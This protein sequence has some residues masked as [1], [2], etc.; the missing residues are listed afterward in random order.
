MLIKD[1]TERIND[2]A[3]YMFNKL[4]E[5]DSLSSDSSF[6]FKRI[7]YVSFLD[8]ISACIFPN[9]KN[10]SRFIGLIDRFSHWE[11][12]DRVC[13]VH[14]SEFCTIN[15]DPELEKIRRFVLNKLKSWQENNDPSGTIEVS[16]NPKYDEVS[17][18][19]IRGKESNLSYQL[20]DFKMVNLLYQ[21]R[22]SLV[23]QFQVKGREL[24]PLL[25]E[26]PF[27]AIYSDLNSDNKL[28]PSSIELIYP[29]E[30]LSSLCKSILENTVQYFRRGN[31]DPFATFYAGK[32]WLNDLNK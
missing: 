22:N 26:V 25:P 27:Y 4:S 8:S 32:F 15:S 19:W 5:I 17:N 23:H 18:L 13:I 29:I 10:R 12:R 28:V 6:L 11:D 14:L 20:S 1:Y 24:G 16:E 9:S 3:K 30:F 21:Q 31:L 7:L 2:F